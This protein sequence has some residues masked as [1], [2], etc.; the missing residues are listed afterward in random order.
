MKELDLAWY[1]IRLHTRLRRFDQKRNSQDKINIFHHARRVT[2]K[3]SSA[4]I[5]FSVGEAK[6]PW[7]TDDEA[8]AI[9][10]ERE[11]LLEKLSGRTNLSANGTK[12]HLGKLSRGCTICMDGYWGCNYINGRC[13]RNC[14]YCMRDHSMQTE[15]NSKSDGFHFGN[16]EEHIEFLKTFQ[17]RGVGFSG[18][19]PLLVLDRLLEHIVAIRKELGSTIYLWMYTNGD[20]VNRETLSALRDAGL[21][22]IRFDLSARDYDLSPL[23]LAKEYIPT[24]AVEIPAIPEDFLLLK[25]LLIDIQ[26]VGVNHLN[27]HQLMAG[28]RNWKALCRRHYHFSF[29]STPAVHESELCAL[30]LILYACEQNLNL[31]INYCSV[32]YKFRFQ[33]RASRM[34]RALV[35]REG[36]QEIT[37]AG[38]IRSLCISDSADK[39]EALARRL[40]GDHVEPILWKEECDHGAIALHS[41][42]MSYVDWSSATLAIKYYQAGVALMNKSVRFEPGNLKR[43]KRTVKT[44]TGLGCAAFDCWHR[45]YVQKEAATDVFSPTHL[46]HIG[47]AEEKNLFK[48]IIG[49]LLSVATYEQL[50]AGLPDVT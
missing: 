13:H 8:K 39:I 25:K 38:Y 35:L 7:F 3:L 46:K 16:P 45:L 49:Q 40:K 42:L 32:A 48:N 27:L 28:Q 31:P 5:R 44:V 37:E 33:G 12:L 6:T 10:Q 18:G 14:F 24:V 41:S 22:E 47:V 29:Q 17:I 43:D 1:M 26:A 2:S 23:V 21:N 19:E 15:P 30:R 34:R 4:L 20:L 9:H 11:K 36:F 50:E